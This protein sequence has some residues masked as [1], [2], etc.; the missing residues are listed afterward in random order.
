MKIDYLRRKHYNMDMFPTTADINLINST[1]IECVCMLVRKR[2]SLI[3]GEVFMRDDWSLIVKTL[4]DRKVSVAVISNGFLFSEKILS[5]LKRVNVESVA[6]SLDGPQEI[7]DKFRCEGS[8]SRAIKAIDRLSESSIPVS[9]ISTLHSLNVPQLEEMYKVLKDKNIF[10]W[11]LQACSPMGNARQQD[12]SVDIDFNEVISFVE[13][14]KDNEDFIIGIADNIGYYTETE[15]YLRGN[16]N[17]NGPFIGCSAGLTNIGID[18]VGNVRGCEAMYDDCFIEGNLTEQSLYEI[19]NNPD[20]F[21]YNR[22]FTCN[23]LTGR[24]AECKY[25]TKCAG[26]CRSYNYFSHG[27]MYESSRCVQKYK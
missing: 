1:H 12:F 13:K 14:H 27:K 5:E 18:S 6:I 20:A 11:Q 7:H 4:T 9:V 8:F 24:C 2:V 23:N 25:S 10:A 17:G 19:W 22:N 21:S 3:G 16:R 26:G 15:G